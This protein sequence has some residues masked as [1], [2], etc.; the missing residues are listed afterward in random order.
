MTVSHFLFHGLTLGLH[1]ELKQ[2][3]LQ[4][5]LAGK[6]VLGGRDIGPVPDARPHLHI[7]HPVIGE[8]V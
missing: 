3:G 7:G 4:Q 8:A 6:Q 1:G 2:V 5:V